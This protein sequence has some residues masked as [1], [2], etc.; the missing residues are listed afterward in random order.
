M[1]IKKKSGVCYEKSTHLNPHK[2]KVSE[3]KQCWKIQN[4]LGGNIKKKKKKED[5]PTTE[6]SD[7]QIQ[8]V[9]VKH[10]SSDKILFD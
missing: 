2:V 3:W 4:C 6:W 8:M 9:L 1:L 5:Y 10:W 7:S